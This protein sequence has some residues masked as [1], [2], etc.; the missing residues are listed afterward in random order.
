MLSQ[1]AE[2]VGG[3]YGILQEL[4]ALK[5]STD[6]QDT[7]LYG[8]LRGAMTTAITDYRAGNFNAQP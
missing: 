7:A 4:R 2:L 6:A 1:L 8:E 3:I 5:E